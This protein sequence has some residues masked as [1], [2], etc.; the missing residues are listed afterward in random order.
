MY[1]NIRV[2]EDLLDFSDRGRLFQ[3]FTVLTAKVRPP[4][5]MF[6]WWGQNKSA[7]QFLVFL[8]WTSE[9]FLRDTLK[10]SGNWLPFIL[11]KASSQ[12]LMCASL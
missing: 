6:L 7:I 3:S 8:E 11:L 2:K 9:F 1:S 5:E 4:S 12:R 10:Q